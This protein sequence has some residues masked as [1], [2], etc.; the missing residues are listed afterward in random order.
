MFVQT[1]AK[2][3]DGLERFAG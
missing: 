2:D 3:E 1:L